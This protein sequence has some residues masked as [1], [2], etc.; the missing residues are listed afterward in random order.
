M[1]SNIRYVAQI[2]NIKYRTLSEAIEAV[3]T[4]ETILMIGDTTEN[5]TVPENKKF[6]LDLGEQTITGMLINNGNVTITGNGT[7][8]MESLRK[9]DSDL[10]TDEY[11][12]NLIKN[13]GTLTINSGNYKV[14]KEGGTLIQNI[15]TMTMNSGNV[16][17]QGDGWGIEN[18]NTFY[19]NGGT[20]TLNYEGSGT[21][22][23]NTSGTIEMTGG[24]INSKSYGLVVDGGKVTTYG[25]SINIIGTGGAHAVSVRNTGKGTFINTNIKASCNK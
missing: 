10:V 23:Y 16:E 14:E 7:I 13:N 17:R 11:K 18:Q 24:T 5:N 9:A 3:K 8:Y 19:F 21:G 1:I 15:G 4:D 6:T 25:G 2:G 12:E 20:I 22:L